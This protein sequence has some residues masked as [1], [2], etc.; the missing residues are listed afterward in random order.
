MAKNINKY[1][2]AILGAARS[3]FG[4]AKLLKKKGVSVFMSESQ[5]IASL[6]Y[7]DEKSLKEYD[8]PYEVGGHTDKIFDYDIIIKSPGI[9]LNSE[10]ILKALEKNKK[11]VSEI[12]VAFLLCPAPVIAVTGTNG[13]TTTTV[14]TGEFFKNAGID[15]K[16]CGNVGLAFS[17]IIDEVSDKSVVVLET[18]SFQLESIEFFRPRISMIL[19]FTP[20]HI[21]WHGSLENYFN[22]KLK[23]NVNQKN[24]DAIIF[25][26]DDE[27]VRNYSLKFKGNI[28]PFS[29]RE[30]LEE[31]GY[32]SGAY[33]NDNNVIYFDKSKNEKCE[34]INTDKIFIRGK[35]NLQNSLASILAAKVFGISND[36]ISNTLINFKGVEHRIEPVREIKGVK[37]YNDSKATNFD[38]TYVALES[39]KKN[40][41]LIIGGKKGANNFDLIRDFVKERVKCMIAIGQSKNDIKNYFNEFKEVILED[42][43]ESAVNKAYQI[44]KDGDFVLF[45]PAYKSFDM[46]DNFEHR[47][48]EF[49]K[50]VNQI[51]I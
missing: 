4:I 10:V 3:G 29:V 8:I 33:V 26:Y 17:E 49:K 22:A 15:T 2:Y 42:T 25:N 39:F 12:E 18:S 13:K 21:D 38:S 16:V 31:K 51:K 11:I 9:P 19:N 7:F 24:D 23:I 35:H 47:G 44:S 43:L 14:L 41:I 30:N 46:F 5:D 40:I 48:E 45:S 50:F 32:L 28:L 1:S 6:K 34:V 37:Y 36:I 20:D 27:I